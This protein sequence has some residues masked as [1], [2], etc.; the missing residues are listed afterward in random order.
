M[1][2]EERKKILQLVADGKL[3]ADEAANLMRALQEPAEEEIQVFEASTGFSEERSEAPELDEVKRRASR[4]SAGFLWLGII[5][6]ALT[7]WGMFSIQQGAGLNFWFFCLAMPLTLGIIFIALGG[8]NRSARWLYVNVD[9]SGKEDGPRK[10]SIAF[11]LPLG[12]AA[13]FLR[14]FGNHI[15]GLK[16]TNVDEV[17][18]AIAMAKNIREPLIVNV[19]ES[20]EGGDRVQVFIG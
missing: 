1:S 13:W 18:Q 9:R 5:V 6:T 10:I 3:T 20:D 16:K 19:D 4:F 14:N 11:P 12:F 8:G 2:A 15:E 17:I 7:A